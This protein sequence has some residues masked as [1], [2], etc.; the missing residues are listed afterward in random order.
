ML[1]DTTNGHDQHIVNRFNNVSL[2]FDHFAL[3]EIILNNFCDDQDLKEITEILEDR[4]DN[5]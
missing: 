1:L 2:H 4:L 5:N 3:L